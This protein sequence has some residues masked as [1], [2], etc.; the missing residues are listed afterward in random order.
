MEVSR[1]MSKL[2]DF[3]GHPMHLI[4]LDVPTDDVWEFADPILNWVLG[5]GRLH[6]DSQ[7]L[8]QQNGVVEEGLCKFIEYLLVEKH[9]NRFT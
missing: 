6:T 8:V 1:D 9:I 2:A 4:G 5:F 3:S 7:A